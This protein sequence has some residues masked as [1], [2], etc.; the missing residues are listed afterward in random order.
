LEKT[1]TLTNESIIQMVDA[2]FSEGT[3]VRR[4]EQ[5]PA[6]FSLSSAQ[7]A[8][9]K[10]RRVSATVIAA[11]KAAMGEEPSSSKPPA[12]NNPEK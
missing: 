4:I 2:G 8:E 7:V 10:K 11:M 5:S 3:I 12:A 9:L 6:E 1:P